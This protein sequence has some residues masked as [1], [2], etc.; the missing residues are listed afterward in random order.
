[1]HTLKQM[2]F[3]CLTSSLR[4][5]QTFPNLHHTNLHQNND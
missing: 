3:Q 5:S 4:L 1:M 2:E